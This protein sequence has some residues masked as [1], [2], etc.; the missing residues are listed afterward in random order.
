MEEQVKAIIYDFK[1]AGWTVQQIEKEL[2]F[3]N[4]SLSK[5]ISDFRFSKL[6][7]LHKKE[8]GKPI[9]ITKKLEEK[10]AENNE[11]EKKAEIEEQRNPT[12]MSKVQQMILEQEKILKQK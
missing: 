9:T 1:S 8:I 7:E 6:I 5:K 11:P 12:A 3:S 4:G 2:N 10:I